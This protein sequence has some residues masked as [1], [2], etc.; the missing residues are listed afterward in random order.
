[1]G[2]SWMLDIKPAV[3]L[4]ILCGLAVR[5]FAQQDTFIINESTFKVR[6]AMNQERMV[7]RGNPVFYQDSI[8]EWRR[9]DPNWKMSGDTLAYV[10]SGVY[11]ASV[12]T[13]GNVRVRFKGRQVGW[14]L[15]GLVYFD[16]S[17]K[18]RQVIRA[19]NWKKPSLRGDSLLFD[20]LFP[21]V[22][23]A[24]RYHPGTLLGYLK[25]SAAA[26][27]AL[28]TPAS[29]GISASNA[30]L[31]LV[32]KMDL[33]DLKDFFDGDDSV[34]WADRFDS[35]NPV[36]I[37][38][39][40]ESVWGLFPQEIIYT[41]DSTFGN[42]L[43][44][45]T[46]LKTG[47]D[48]LM[49]LGCK[50]DEFINLPAGEVIF[51]DA[52][53]IRGTSKIIDSYLSKPSPTT[54]YGSSASSYMGRGGTANDIFRSVIR[55]DFSDIPSGSTITAAVDSHYYDLG[56]SCTNVSQDFDLYRLTRLWDEAE[57]SWNYAERNPDVSWTTAG[58]DYSN[59]II[60][61]SVGYP[62]G[63]LTVSGL[64]TAVQNWVDGNWSNYGC[65]WR[66][67][68]E[69]GNNSC[70]VF[71]TCEHASNDTRLYVTY[72]LPGA[73]KNSRRS[74]LVRMN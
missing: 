72:T 4:S 50:Y 33:S 73:A 34:R 52:V 13:L 54:N 27:A 41:A 36:F 49:I 67:T 35:H 43:L 2:R 8:G 56:S 62:N 64:E 24:L 25:I 7:C 53:Q 66:H 32:Y 16:D 38:D 37:K 55:W 70:K 46:F 19:A 26:R 11:A 44:R 18:N 60:S 3:L 22:N 71:Y 65:I 51:D 28:P 61:T 17:N 31:C 57:V 10:K 12:D 48:F 9:I 20:N 39:S 58:G 14:R 68:D 42:P 59:L 15:Q 74:R 30:W 23:Y 69:T 1:M 5:A 21:G 29:L 45:K 6:L 63:W 40:W 47:T